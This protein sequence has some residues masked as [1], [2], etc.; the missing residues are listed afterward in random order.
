MIFYFACAI[1]AWLF[2]IGVYGIVTS[3]NLV[4]LV[5]CLVVVQAS[6]YVLLSAVGYRHGGVAPVFS[7]VTQTQ[8]TVDSVVQALMLT[9]IVVEATVVALLLA[10][11]VQI[12]K[13]TG[14]VD[15]NNVN[16]LRG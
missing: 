7:D 6:T 9:D 2:L 15:P 16:L 1:A 5:L 4:H 14:I 11:T 8:T 12:K 10:I 3:D 13:R